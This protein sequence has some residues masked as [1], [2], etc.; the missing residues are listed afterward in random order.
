MAASGWVWGG[1]VEVESGNAN[2]LSAHATNGN[3][4]C[5]SVYTT[6]TTG[7]GNTLYRVVCLLEPCYF[8][9]L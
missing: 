3:V 8:Y 7:E 5:L 1:A 2:S 9:I 6:T 4:I